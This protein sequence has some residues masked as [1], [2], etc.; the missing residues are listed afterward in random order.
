MTKKHLFLIFVVISLVLTGCASN[1]GVH[2][3]S[4]P[5]EKL[6]TLKIDS[7]LY[8][9][10]FDGEDVKWYGLFHQTTGAIV[11]IPSG[12]HSF[13]MHYESGS[14]YIRYANDVKF[15]HTFEAGKTYVME[16]TISGNRVSIT[17]KAE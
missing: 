7:D 6:C 3:P 2:D 1:M 15:S 9:H 16:P 5:Q 11:Q 12:H 17:V 8:V 13:V 14:R 4:V 10:Q